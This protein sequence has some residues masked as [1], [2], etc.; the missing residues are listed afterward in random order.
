MAGQGDRTFLLGD[1][2]DIFMRW[3]ILGQIGAERMPRFLPSCAAFTTFCTC[4]NST[5]RKENV[6]AS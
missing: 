2:G 6:L 1:M 5:I 4:R 3:F